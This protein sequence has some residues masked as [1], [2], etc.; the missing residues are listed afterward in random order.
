MG[1]CVCASMCAHMWCVAGL[2]GERQKR[3]RSS[4]GGTFTSYSRT[5]WILFSQWTNICNCFFFFLIN[6]KCLK[7]SPSPLKKKILK[8]VYHPWLSPAKIRN[9]CPQVIRTEIFF[10]LNGCFWIM[11]KHHDSSGYIYLTFPRVVIKPATDQTDPA[12]Q[13]RQALS[14]PFPQLG[15]RQKATQKVS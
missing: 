4:R 14:Q 12:V 9:C 13:T 11:Y 7:S 2:Q 8:Y 15:T 5:V 6:E 3:E 1:L 10:F